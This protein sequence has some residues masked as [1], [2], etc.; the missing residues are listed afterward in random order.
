MTPFRR[1][2]LVTVVLL[3]CV[4]CDQITKMA[5]RDHLAFSQPTFYLAGILH[6]EYTENTGAFLSF[7]SAFPS[8]IRFWVFT[9]LTGIA[10]AGMVVLILVHR[11]LSPADLTGLSLIAAGGIGNLIDR[12]LNN[13]AV[14][15]FINVGVGSLRTGIFNIAD[16]A[17]LA[18]AGV[19]IFLGFHQRRR[20]CVHSK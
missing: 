1:V 9:I 7:G 3:T 8:G 17:I 20:R 13:G 12:A 2:L 4:G 6:L 14:I 19:A 15:D 10:L 5:A 16:V 18:G 11:S